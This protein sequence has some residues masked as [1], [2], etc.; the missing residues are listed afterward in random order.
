MRCSFISGKP[1]DTREVKSTMQW[2]SN[3]NR[4]S[5]C[6]IFEYLYIKKNRTTLKQNFKALM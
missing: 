2:T 5:C 1:V 6:H 3:I 4:H